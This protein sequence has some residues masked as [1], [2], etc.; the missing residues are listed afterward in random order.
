NFHAFHFSLLKNNLSPAEALDE[1]N[2]FRILCATRDDTEEAND[3]VMRLLGV[4]MHGH[5]CPVMITENDYATGLFNGD[6]GLCLNTPT[7]GMKVWFPPADA[8]GA[9]R[10]F[11]VSQLPAHEPC[12]AMTVHKSQGSG[13]DEVLLVLPDTPLPLLTRELLYTGITRAR[14]R[15]VIS[16]SEAV[17]KT[18]VARR[19]HRASGLTAKLKK[20]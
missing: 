8:S 12:F 20:V 13:F 11:A 10:P 4:R 16:A 7:D 5:G 18:A 3:A 15:C 14:K 1:F 19:A 9:A 6:T 17:F 2:R